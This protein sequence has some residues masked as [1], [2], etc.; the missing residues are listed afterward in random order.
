M[1]EELI[2][3]LREAEASLPLV[4]RRRR[5]AFAV[6]AT[7]VLGLERSS[8]DELFADFEIWSKALFSFPIALPGT[9]CAR[10]LVSRQRILSR[11]KGV[12]RRDGARA[13]GLDLLS[14]GFDE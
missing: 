5:F 1:I 10:A 4:P 3:E 13:G 7:T 9:P 8:S 12:L 2:I 14:S 6:I 11:L